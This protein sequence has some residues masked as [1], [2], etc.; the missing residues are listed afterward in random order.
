MAKIFLSLPF[1]FLSDTSKESQTLEIN[2]KDIS[3]IYT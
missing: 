3:Q 2:K 1:A